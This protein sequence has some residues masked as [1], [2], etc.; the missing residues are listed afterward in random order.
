LTWQGYLLG[1]FG[2]GG[3]EGPWAYANLGVLV[4]LVVGF[5]G[6]LL[7]ARGSIRRQEA[8]STPGAPSTPD[9]LR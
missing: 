9:D 1:P 3:R 2:L 5:L 7:F 8:L 6:T 4:A